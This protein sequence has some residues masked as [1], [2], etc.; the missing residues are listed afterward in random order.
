MLF[1]CGAGLGHLHQ[2]KETFLH[3]GAAGNG[4]ANHR[5]APPEGVFKQRGYL[6]SYSG[7]HA[8]HHEAGL[9]DEKAAGQIKDPCCAADNGLLLAAGKADGVYLLLV[10]GKIKRV[11]RPGRSKHFPE[12]VFIRYHPYTLA[13]S[14]AE[15]MAAG[16]HQVIGQKAAYGY[17]FAAVGTF[18]FRLSGVLLHRSCPAAALFQF[19]FGF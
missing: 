19:V 4:V 17:I 15:M 3:A 1:N 11:A 12:A 10:T 8:S 7:P 6:F 14:H 16:A 2:G 13:G 5:H 9:H 18:L